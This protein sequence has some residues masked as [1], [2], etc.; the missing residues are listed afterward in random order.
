MQNKEEIFDMIME[1]HKNTR[2]SAH[3]VIK[4][5]IITFIEYHLREGFMFF[6]GECLMMGRLYAPWYN[7]EI[8][9]TDSLLFVKPKAQG[10][11]LAKIAIKEFILWAK[12][13]GA[14][15]I[16]I[17]QSS[18]VNLNK[19]QYLAASLGLNKIGETY[20]V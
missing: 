4:E 9:A 15:D 10:K 1:M 18:G 19:F 13:K 20:N 5:K 8:H 12:S 3:S 17:A 2:F 14:T 11:G 16:T 7:D 6:D